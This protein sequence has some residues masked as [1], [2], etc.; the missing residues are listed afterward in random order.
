MSFLNFIDTG[1]IFTL[2]LILVV[3]GA[4]ML[5]CYRRLNVLENSVIEHGKILH[6]FIA[7][8]NQSRQSPLPPYR[9]R[10]NT[11]EESVEDE[12]RNIKQVIT[13]IDGD[14]I[15]VSDNESDNESYNDESDNDESDNDESD[16]DESDNSEE[17][18]DNEGEIETIGDELDIQDDIMEAD[19]DI[20]D[21]EDVKEFVPSMFQNMTLNTQ[22]DNNTDSPIDISLE[23]FSKIIT[24][25][26]EEEKPKF[27]KMKVDELREYAVTHNFINTQEA[28][29]LKKG[30]LLKIV[31]GESSTA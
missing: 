10:L 20:K 28:N 11:I 30:D 26:E 2:G 12:N 13:N 18:S 5:Y 17:V 31:N 9:N 22:N 1:F 7:N 19:F 25:T 16:N 27:N 14:K 15:V 3:G 6:N 21:V 8:Y 29:K 23:T 24:L 4:I